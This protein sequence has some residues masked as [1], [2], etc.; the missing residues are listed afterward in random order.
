MVKRPSY[1]NPSAFLTPPA[2]M[3]SAPLVCNQAVGTLRA[4]CLH[5]IHDPRAVQPVLDDLGKQAHARLGYLTHQARHG[6]W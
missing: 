3:Q 5:A 6:S 4:P 1:A 2:N